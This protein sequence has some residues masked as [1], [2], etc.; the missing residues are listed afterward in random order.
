M[1][2]ERARFV[3]D[4]P[5]LTT[6]WPFVCLIHDFREWFT[7]QGKYIHVFHPISY[8][9]TVQMSGYLHLWVIYCV[10]RIPASV[11][12]WT[13]FWS[14]TLLFLS[15]AL[16]TYT[17]TSARLTSNDFSPLFFIWSFLMWGKISLV[18]FLQDLRA[19]L[20]FFS[21]VSVPQR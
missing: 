9:G 17:L 4:T 11:S 14:T 21:H 15:A 12:V 6:D 18:F 3:F 7:I 2:M 13:F 16:H 19:W 1:S 8:F 10:A 5:F 20:F